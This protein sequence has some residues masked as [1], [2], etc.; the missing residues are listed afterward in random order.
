MGKGILDFRSIEI[1]GVVL[2]LHLYFYPDG[3]G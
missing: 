3:L 2:V 1:L